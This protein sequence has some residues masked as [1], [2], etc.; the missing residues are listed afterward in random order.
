MHLSRA[1]FDCA[2]EDFATSAFRLQLLSEYAVPEEATSLAAY[3]T[4]EPFPPRTPDA[5]VETM[6][7]QVARGKSWTTV[8]LLPKRLTPYLRFL[9]DWGYVDDAARGARIRFLL[10]PHASRLRTL[11]PQDFWLFDDERLVLMHY[12]PI[13]E[14]LG[15][16]EASS[17]AA[18]A[19]ARKARAFALKHAV[20]LRA[21]LAR[22]RSG[23]LG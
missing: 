19:S 3:L 15:A 21:I 8:H 11:A 18:L 4:G 2:F 9:I 17:S 7:A 12:S 23:S 14:F 20:E 10:P 6:A 5:W 1:E 16:E 22:R 13:G